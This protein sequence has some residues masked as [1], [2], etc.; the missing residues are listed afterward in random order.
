[1]PY[2]AGGT[3]Q[4]NSGAP[5]VSDVYHSGNVY[6]NNVLVALWQPPGQ[7]SAFSGSVPEGPIAISPATN[8]SNTN[9]Y[10]AYSQNPSASKNPAAASNGVK[11]NYPGTPD[12]E[13]TGG[14]IPPNTNASAGDVKS[15]LDKVYEEAKRGMWRESGQ[16][17]KPSNPNIVG[18]WKDLG[19]PNS[20]YWSTDQTPW[21]MG[22][23]NFALK[24]S[25]Y[26]YVQEASSWAIRNKPTR[27][28]ATP[29]AVN[30][31]QPG[32][33][34]LWDFGHVNFV[35]QANNGKLNFMGGN[36]T[37]TS[38]NKNNPNDGDVSISWPLGWT[39]NR[40][41]IAGIWRPAK[42]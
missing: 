20:A 19:Y 27:W 34:V 4:G 39:S 33:I 29:V 40:G 9:K 35:Y 2:V 7:S 21:C 36:Q 16:N 14:S 25:G 5:E 30:Q 23:V 10:D 13:E 22:F 38:G 42:T 15:F 31:A 3:S 6:I 12:S 1:M 11:E 41:G 8:D 18:I 26:R 32:D 24:R 28:N 17:G 37:P